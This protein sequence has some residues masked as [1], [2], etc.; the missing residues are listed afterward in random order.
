[1]EMLFVGKPEPYLPCVWLV[2]V[3]GGCSDHGE[4]ISPRSIYWQRESDK[5]GILEWV[6]PMISEGIANKSVTKS[7]LSFMNTTG[8]MPIAK[9]PGW[10]GKFKI[11]SS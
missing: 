2:L 7:L 10:A 9:L 6:S 4:R 5:Y 1:M 11:Y 3:G 8:I